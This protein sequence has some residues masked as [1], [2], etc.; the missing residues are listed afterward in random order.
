M[1]LPCKQVEIAKD[2]SVKWFYGDVI[3]KYRSKGVGTYLAAL[4]KNKILERGGI[5][6]YG[7]SV[8]NYHSWNI[9]LNCGFKPTWL[10]IGARKI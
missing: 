4:L 7:T 6:F 10:E 8:S 9:A 5:P 1:F 2:Y 3:L